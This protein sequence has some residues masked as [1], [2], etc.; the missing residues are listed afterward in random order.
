MGFLEIGYGVGEDYQGRGLGELSVR[1][2][3][4]KIFKE[5]NFGRIIAHVSEENI[6]SRS[7]LEKIGFKKEGV[8]REHFIINKIPVNECVYGLLKREFKS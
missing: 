6:A 8:L 4:N 3:V 7:V 1:S 2:L 5:T